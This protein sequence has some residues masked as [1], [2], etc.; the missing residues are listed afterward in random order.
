MSLR[1]RILDT[2]GVNLIFVATVGLLLWESR[3][4]WMAWQI[5]QVKEALGV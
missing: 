3:V 1:S 4:Q 2:V 5:V